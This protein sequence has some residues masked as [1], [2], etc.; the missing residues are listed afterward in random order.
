MTSSLG[1]PLKKLVKGANGEYISGNWT[2]CPSLY[3][4]PMI[5]DYV[6]KLPN[7]KVIILPDFT[8]FISKILADK[9][10][11]SRKAGGEAFQR[12]WELAADTL[13]NF[14]LTQI[15]LR[16]DLIAITEY[17]SEY[18]EVQDTFKI[19]VPGGKMLEEKI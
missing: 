7:I 4:L 8:H 15:N 10:F 17:H 9:N 6:N 1:E 5:L 18:N 2:L 3:T 14:M 13:N 16:E 19:F 11:I 12:F